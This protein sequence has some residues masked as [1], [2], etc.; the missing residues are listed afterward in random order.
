MLLYVCI[1]AYIAYVVT[2]WFWLYVYG[3]YGLHA[4]VVICLASVVC[5]YVGTCV[6]LLLVWPYV[7]RIEFGIGWLCV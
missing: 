6:V 7:Y 4:S 1:F 5:F 3:W 2:V